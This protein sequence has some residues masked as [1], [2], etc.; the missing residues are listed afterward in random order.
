MS[1][2]SKQNK[3]LMALSLLAGGAS[4]LSVGNV[5]ADTFKEYKAGDFDLTKQ[6]TKADYPVMFDRPTG[7]NA[8][9]LGNAIVNL[10][11]S[12][13]LYKKAV[14]EV[15]ELKDPSIVNSLLDKAMNGDKS[16]RETIVKLI[17]FY[18][19][20]GGT[21]ITTQGGQKY[22]VENLDEPINTIAVAFTNGDSASNK[23]VSTTIQGKFGAVKTTEDVMKAIDTY[24]AGISD[25]YQKAFDSYDAK[26][27]AQGADLSKLTSYE[28]IKP[29]L[30]SYEGMYADGASIIRKSVLAESGTT[31]AAVAFFES[32]VITGGNNNGDNGST[33]KNEVKRVTKFID[34]TT[35]KELD[36]SVEGNDFVD[37]HPIKEYTHVD[38]KTEGNTRTHYYEKTP[39]K[40]PEK[41]VIT[42]WIDKDTGKEVKP[43][44]EGTHEKGKDVPGYTYVTTT[45]DKDG[46]TVHEYVKTPEK[47]VTTKWIDKDTGKDVK[48]PQEGTHEKGKDVP[49]YTY[50]TT[51]K[52]KDG[53][54]VHEYVKT[55]E[56]KVV[57][58]HWYD[59][60]NP[61]EPLLPAREGSFPD[62]DGVSDI[63][64]YKLKGEPIVITEEIAKGLDKDSPFK[65]GDTV[66]LYEKVE[67]PKTNTRWVDEATGKDIPGHEPKEGSF[68]DKEG[69]DVP[70][71]TLVSTHTD[72]KGNVVNTYTKKPV[73]TKVITHWVDKATGKDIPGHEPKD[74]AFPDKEG[75]DVK[76]YKFVETVEETDKDGN[77]VIK[78]IYEVDA[79]KVTT[80]Y[81][82]K[83]DRKRIVDDV[84]G[85]EFAKELDFSNDKDPEKRK[86]KLVGVETSKD[87]KTKTYIY[88]VQETPKAETPKTEKP[89]EKPQGKQLPQT[90]DSNIPVE[91][92]LITLATGIALA[93]TRRKESKESK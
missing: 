89:V 55:P 12:S 49:G 64:G 6:A 86:L 29:V 24:G 56:K 43:P 88:D 44:Q 23:K 41:K 21:Q 34:K 46:N 11:T 50:V 26:L 28:A 9:A 93:R 19:S 63:K 31:E 92:G 8:S 81:I 27:K 42:K 60:N 18:N 53:N 70:G 61:K 2:I 76:G 37:S 13:D 51:T 20:L 77:K 45:K 62:N 48:P 72:D 73:E 54:I 15:P 85:K 91:A 80:R 83:S 90:G 74:G 17:N 68:P 14:V 3:N 39:E 69:D 38:T 71:Y 22:T 67:A 66:N 4:V 59:A 84:E 35:G 30:D 87:G 75:D 40:T 47:K 36:K 7:V 5:S 10:G 82:T 65:V 25:K 33:D 1:Y 57:R 79:A 58:T 16:A 52:D 32:A 78:N